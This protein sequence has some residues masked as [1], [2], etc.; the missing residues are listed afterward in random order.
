MR[1]LLIYLHGCAKEYYGND[2]IYSSEPTG[3]NKE[4]P[5]NT[6]AHVLR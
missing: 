4:H 1:D 6:L 3:K 5:Y 2:R